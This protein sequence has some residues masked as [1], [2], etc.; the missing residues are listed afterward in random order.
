MVASLLRERVRRVCCV[1][2]RPALRADLHRRDCLTRPT[3]Q[4]GHH[5]CTVPS[6][7]HRHDTPSAIQ[8]VVGA[9]SLATKRAGGPFSGESHQPRHAEDPD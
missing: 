8:I 9:T 6:L 7:E 3:R 1:S 5:G 4:S 2:R